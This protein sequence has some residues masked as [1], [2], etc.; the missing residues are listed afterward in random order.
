M[1][2]GVSDWD[3]VIGEAALGLDLA[4]VDSL[5]NGVLTVPD[6]VP[7]DLAAGPPPSL[8][9]ARR[10]PAPAIDPGAIFRDEALEFRAAAATCPAAWSASART[11]SPGPTG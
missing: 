9:L 8:T 2:G 6:T 7:D 10:P 4:R 1:R 3:A 11:G 5:G